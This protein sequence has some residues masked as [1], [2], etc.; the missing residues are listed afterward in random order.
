MNYSI[1]TPVLLVLV[2]TAA[3]AFSFVLPAISEGIAL[4]RARAAIMMNPATSGKVIQS[5][6]AGLATMES[7]A[8][9]GLILTIFITTRIIFR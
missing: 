8:I 2:S 7:T 5:L 9:Y 6:F 4:T 1:L 3:I